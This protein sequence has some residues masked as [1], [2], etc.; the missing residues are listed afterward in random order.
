MNMEFTHDGVTYEKD[1]GIIEANDGSPLCAFKNP[2][3][4]LCKISQKAKDCTTHDFDDKFNES[5]KNQTNLNDGLPRDSDYKKLCSPANDNKS[6]L[7]NTTKDE[8]KVDSSIMKVDPKI[9]D[10]IITEKT[11]K[12]IDSK[13][14]M[15]NKEYIDKLND[16][17]QLVDSLRNTFLELTEDEKKSLSLLLSTRPKGSEIHY[18]NFHQRVYIWSDIESINI[19]NPLHNSTKNFTLGIVIYNSTIIKIQGIAGCGKTTF[20]KKFYSKYGGL[21]LT[22]SRKV[23]IDLKD[24]DEATL[25][26]LGLIMFLALKL[27]SKNVILLGDDKQICDVQRDAMWDMDNAPIPFITN[28]INLRHTYRCPQDITYKCV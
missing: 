26:H 2:K 28:L 17:L 3:G 27:K 4:H 15:F 1:D 22:V 12:T 21:I 9:E 16:V 10:T 11:T 24:F 19:P 25:V 5:L 20:I 18:Q 6:K 7:K 23:V 14:T 8:H 13:T